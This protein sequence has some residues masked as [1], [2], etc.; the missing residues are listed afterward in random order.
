[1]RPGENLPGAILHSEDGGKTWQ[2]LASGFLSTIWGSGG[3]FYAVGRLT[4]T[5]IRE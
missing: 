2:K 3:T 5:T 1:V 4:I